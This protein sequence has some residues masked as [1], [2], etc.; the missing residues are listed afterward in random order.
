MSK[1]RTLQIL[2]HRQ[3]AAVKT[4]PIDFGV[5]NPDLPLGEAVYQSMRRCLRKGIIRP[6]DRI[7]EDEV[8]TSLAVSRTPVREA[9]GRL[10]SK[11]FLVPIGAKGLVVRSLD[12]A[13]VLQL[14]AMREI[15]EGAAARLAATQ[16]SQP[17]IDALIAIQ[18]AIETAAGDPDEMARLNVVFHESIFRSAKN[19]YLTEA[20]EELQDVIALLGPTTLAVRG[21]LKTA[22]VEHRA[23]IAA[24]AAKKAKEAEELAASHIREALRVRLQILRDRDDHT[25]RGW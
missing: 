13:E 16:V 22:S 17:E 7:K 15:L 8:A 5:L 23:I 21:R 10:V 1:S 14:Y 20:L 18:D 3:Q 25:A 19:Q 2:P 12:I 24:I 9:M 11:G 4:R 6:G